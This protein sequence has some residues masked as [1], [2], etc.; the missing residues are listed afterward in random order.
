MRRAQRTFTFRRLTTPDVLL[1]AGWAVALDSAARTGQ[2]R[3]RTQMSYEAVVRA[4][5]GRD[6][7]LVIGA[8]DDSGLVG[9]AQSFAVRRTAYFTSLCLAAPALRGSAGDALYW[10]T[11][12]SWALAADVETV[13]LGLQLGERPG[14]E[15]Y[16]RT[17]GAET[18]GV[19]IVSR[20]RAPVALVL[21][22]TRP[23]SFDRLM[24]V[25]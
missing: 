3:E 1:R 25:A 21:R 13:S 10:L 17:F 15:P 24:G 20:L 16:K 11:L 22:A 8:F 23:A 9:Y 19:P 4:R 6:S 2:R 5:Y 18:L 14:I 7:G 12:S